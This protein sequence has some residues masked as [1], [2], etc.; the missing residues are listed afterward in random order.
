MR[1]HQLVDVWPLPR[2]TALISSAYLPVS[3]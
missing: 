2:G 1:G 3:I